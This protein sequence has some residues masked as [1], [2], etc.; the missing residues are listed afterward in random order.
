[1][2]LTHDLESLRQQSE[3]NR[4]EQTLA[5]MDRATGDLARSGIVGQSLKLGDAMP[6]FTLPNATGR[7]V[8]SADLLAHGS[9]VV[10]FYRGGWCPYCNLELNALQQ[11]MPE[12][13]AAGASLVAITP[14]LPDYSLS[15]VEKHALTFEVLSDLGN[16][17]ARQFGLVFR[18]PADLRAIYESVGI[19]LL[20]TQGNDHF[21]L[22]IPG[23]FIVDPH[24]TV[25]TAFVDA[26][27][28]KRLEPSEIVEVLQ[29]IAVRAAHV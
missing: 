3:A 28:T 12:I 8:H 1:M 10:S 4:S 2:S 20:T 15:T 23:A 18:V 21:E 6:A 11:K 5:I 13:T 14:E 27:Y 26:D 29:T 19:D 9:L 17:V 24:G 7:M 25:V 22:P 16:E